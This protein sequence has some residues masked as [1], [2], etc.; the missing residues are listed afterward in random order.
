MPQT[1]HSDCRAA[2]RLRALRRCMAEAGYDAFVIPTS[3]PHLCEYQPRD[4]MFREAFSGFTG[5]AGLL[6]VTPFAAALWTDSRYWE[7]AQMELTPLAGSAE[8]VTLMRQGQ[9]D[10]PEPADWLVAELPEGASIA[11]DPNMISAAEFDRLQVRLLAADRSLVCDASLLP[12]V[13]SDRPAPQR[14][15]AFGFTFGQAPRSEKLGAVRQAM[16]AKGAGALFL[17]TLDDIAWLTNLRAHDIAHTPVL[18]GFLLVTDDKCV[19]YADCAALGQDAADS[20]QSDGISLRPYALA[21]TEAPALT[22]GLAVWLDENATS[23]AAAQAFEEVNDIAPVRGLRPTQ[24]LKCIKSAAELKL[25]EDTMAH[26]GAALVELFAWLEDRRRQGTPVTEGDIVEKLHECRL[27]RPGFMEESFATIC[28]F[29]PNAALPHYQPHGAGATLSGDSLLLIDSGGHYEG[30]T[31]DITRTLVWG[32]A[33]R[34]MKRDFTAVLRGHIALAVSQF[35]EG[36]Y[37]SQLDTLARHPLWEIGADYG[38]GTGHGVGFCLSVHE[39]PVHISP[40]APTVAASRVR[41]GL[42][43]SN[44]P[45]LYRAGRWGVRTENLVTPVAAESAA[46]AMSPM[47]VMKTLTLCPIDTRLV[48]TSMMTPYEIWW[49]NDYHRRVREAL[50]PLV[51]ARARAWLVRATDII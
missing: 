4:W 41:K 37:A 48:D 36:C 1:E 16:R 24:S 9:A 5:S 50:A 49:L 29:G 44:E 39:G 45:G 33:S 47:L 14:T 26:D 31:T 2:A 43:L 19:L 12:Q 20:L 30:G 27:S 11:L 10:T 18:T 34:A 46:D 42:V 15:Q 6:I 3:D 23:R 22:R 13:W 8:A 32:E 28:A 25:L 51:S 38:H 35:P 21:L 17:S 7:Q 40:R